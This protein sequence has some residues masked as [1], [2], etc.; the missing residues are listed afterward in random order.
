M[1]WFVAGAAAVTVATSYM[2]SVSSANSQIKNANSASKAEGQ[3]IATERLNATIRNSYSTSL[4]QMQ[5][6]LK[7]KQLATQGAAISAASL[8]AKGD[9]SL[10]AAS[11]GTIG[12]SVDAVTSDIEQK[13]QQA[14]D[15]TYDQFENAV[16]NYNMSLDM[17]VLNTNE[18]APN[19]RQIEDNTPSAGAML[20]QALVSGLGNLA[21]NYTMK[22]MQLGVGSKGSSPAGMG[23]G[24]GF[25][26]TGSIG[27][28]LK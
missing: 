15:Q 12:A 27:F 18:G 5:L 17:M 4:A 25:T 26:G 24:T 20:G 19:V 3:A 23:G 6:G 14:L 7:K 1:T 11:T 28:K 16:E 8:A 13:S 2:G 10:A 22:R 9:A 21:S